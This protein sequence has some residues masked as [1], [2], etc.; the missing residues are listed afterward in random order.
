[1][2]RTKLE[3]SKEELQAIIDQMESEREF[4]NP[5]ELWLAIENTEWAKAMQPRPL[6][7]ATIYQRVKEFG[8]TIKTLPGKKGRQSGEVARGTRISRAEKL[9]KTPGS[10]DYFAQLR[11]IT[12]QRFLPL[13]DRIE[14]GSRSAANKLMCIQCCGYEVK[15]VK[16]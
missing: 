2:P 1:M 14:N 12:P 4:S 13:V 9:S 3:V 10:E 16:F 7:M 11:K 5:S 15:E 8:C 6:K